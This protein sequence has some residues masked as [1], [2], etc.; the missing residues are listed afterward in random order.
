MEM[1]AKLCASGVGISAE[2]HLKTNLL[3][4]SNKVQVSYFFDIKKIK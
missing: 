4:L 1:K 3:D 2:S